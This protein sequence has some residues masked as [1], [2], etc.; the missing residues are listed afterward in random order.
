[1][2][3]TPDNDKMRELILLIC[4]RSVRDPRF[5][6]TKL[7]KLL[8]DV[9]FLAY[10][11]LGK[12]ITG[13][14]YQKLANGPA[15]LHLV[16]VRES[17]IKAGDLKIDVKARGRFHQ[18]RPVALRKAKLNLFTP[19]EVDLVLGRVLRHW[20]KNADEISDWSHRFHGWRDAEIGDTIPYELAL[21]ST[22][23]PTTKEVQWGR[24][25]GP[26]AAAALSK[27]A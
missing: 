10:R 18:H 17:M 21:L 13:C 11:R 6:A 4:K 15:P 24:E 27:N 5:G 3:I 1:M 14:A 2:P 16:P 7:N 22:R 20:K 25:L 26:E 9:D 8:F 23:R 12:P 19:E